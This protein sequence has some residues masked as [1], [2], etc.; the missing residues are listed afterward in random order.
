[1]KEQRPSVSGPLRTNPANLRYFGDGHGKA[2]Y[3]AGSHRWNCIVDHPGPT[4][5]SLFDFG[6]YL[7]WLSSYGLNSIR[8]WVW[9]HHVQPVLQGACTRPTAAVR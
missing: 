6:T 4:R 5:D 8:G 9:E 7:D 3:L 1:M 2:G